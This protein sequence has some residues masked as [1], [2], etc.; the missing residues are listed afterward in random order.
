MTYSL[1]AT[2]KLWSNTLKKI[3][4]KLNEKKTFDSFFAST[5][6]ND[7]SGDVI[8]IVAPSLVAKTVLERQYIDLIKDCLS[9][10]SDEEFTIKF[11]CDAD[12]KRH[13][14]KEVSSQKKVKKSS[15]GQYFNNAKINP[16]L[17]FDNFIVGKS[18][19]EAHQASL[20]VAKNGGTLFNPL[21]IYS[22]SGLGK[23]H[24]LHAIGNEILKTRMPDA[25]ILYITAND[26][27]EEYV[28]FV[29]AEKDN[30]TL[31]EF[32][33]DVD[34]LLFDD[35][36]F[37][38]EKVKT[39]EMF[40]YIYQDMINKGK[41]IIIT[42][43]KQ[44]SELKGLE[45]RLVSR[46]SQ[47]LTVS[48]NEPD[49]QTCVDILKSKISANGIDISKVDE[50]V[51]NFFAEKFSK[52]VRELEGA[53]NRLILHSLS[54]GADSAITLDVAIEAIGALKGGKTLSNQLTEQKII[55][56]V[57]DYYN[58]SVPQLTG[59]GRTE[60]LVLARHLAMYLI[61]LNLDSPLKSIGKAFGGRDHTTVMNALTNVENE[62]KT[63]PQVKAAIDDLQKKI[64]E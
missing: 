23:T 60:Q 57:S 37:L 29:T 33:N 20:Y 43:D 1:S 34:I 35:V 48:V 38:A 56:I 59:K 61:R 8:E 11:I 6:V 25:K 16:S 17:T 55:N 62:L 12:V 28:K 13:E 7:I 47:G 10:V 9:E 63:N 40:F 50:S 49:Q 42:S 27:V 53:I 41:R 44:P 31:K 51:L 18:N 45:D 46:F 21:F 22:H 14:V 2:T 58:I 39:E 3:S 26:F 32:F 30:Q 54:M 52:N 64:K 15:E 24:L 5:Y 36:Q 19:K 4:E